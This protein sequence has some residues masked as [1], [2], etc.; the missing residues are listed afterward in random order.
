MVLDHSTSE[1][2]ITEEQLL[3]FGNSI[4]LSSRYIKNEIIGCLYANFLTLDGKGLYYITDRAIRDFQLYGNEAKYKTSEATY[5]VDV[6][7]NDI[8][9]SF[10]TLD[11]I[12]SETIVTHKRQGW[13]WN[14]SL[15]RL[16][17]KTHDTKSLCNTIRNS[18]KIFEPNFIEFNGGFENLI[19]LYGKRRKT[20]NDYSFEFNFRGEF[21]S[22]T[23][24]EYKKIYLQIEERCKKP[25]DWGG[26]A[27][28]LSDLDA[29]RPKSFI[30]EAIGDGMI[31]QMG[32]NRYSLTGHAALIMN[33]ALYN[34]ESTRISI[35]VRKIENK[36]IVLIADNTL[37]N[38]EFIGHL[39]K[40]G[41]SQIDGW[42]SSKP[43]SNTHDAVCSVESIIY[44]FV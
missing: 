34:Y 43:F 8:K 3:N 6:R 40:L 25:V 42:Y 13:R 31:R 16:M 2:R 26:K 20:Y 5:T 14:K 22:I 37:Y 18:I 9:L 11:T 7:K 28:K 41:F 44:K 32:N 27:F 4:N 15:R 29:F 35:I 1:R 21:K 23:F 36:F 17:F 30:S 10:F 19:K 12:P 39:S 38:T 33:S 24:L